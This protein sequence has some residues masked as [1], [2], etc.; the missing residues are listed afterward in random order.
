MKKH[1]SESEFQHYIHHQLSIEQREQIEAHLYDC[2]SCLSLYTACVE[3]SMQSSIA[4]DLPSIQ[5][6]E[7]IIEVEMNKQEVDI[8][9]RKRFAFVHYVIAASITMALLSSGVFEFMFQQTSQIQHTITTLNQSSH[10]ERW[11]NDFSNWVDMNNK[12]DTQREQ[13]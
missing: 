8:K 7:S 11:T 12:E 3:K 1:Y 2:D 4:M 5:K 6:I 13:K 9:R 10:I